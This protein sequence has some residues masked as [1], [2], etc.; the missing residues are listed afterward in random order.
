M[1]TGKELKGQTV[2]VDGSKVG[3]S[4]FTTLMSYDCKGNMEYIGDAKFSTSELSPKWYI[5]KFEYDSRGNVIAIKT[6]I[7]KL[8]SG[9]GTIDIDITTNAPFITLTINAEVSML[10][11]GDLIKLVTIANPNLQGIVKNIIG[12]VV[13]LDVAGAVGIAAETGTILGTTDL[14]YTINHFDFKDFAKRFWAHREKY[15]YE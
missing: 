15:L 8:Y 9:V 10:R 2:T 5:E 14:L 6:A 7:N 3:E 11:A 1:S 4:I 13:Q 12:N